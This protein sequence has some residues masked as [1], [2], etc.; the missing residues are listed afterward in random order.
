MNEEIEKLIKIQS[1]INKA[2]YHLYVNTDLEKEYNWV[3]FLYFPDT[4]DYS[5]RF[6]HPILSSTTDS[7]EELEKYLAKPDGFKRE[8]YR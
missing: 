8:L 3:L 6:N 2:L 4:K 7:I 1:K 5:I